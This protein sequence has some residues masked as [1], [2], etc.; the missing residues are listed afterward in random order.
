MNQKLSHSFG[1]FFPISP[2]PIFAVCI[3]AHSRFAKTEEVALRRIQSE[4]LPILG[5]HSPLASFATA[6]LP[7]ALNGDKL[8]VDNLLD[9]LCSQGVY[10]QFSVQLHAALSTKGRSPKWFQAWFNSI[11]SSRE[12]TNNIKLEVGSKILKTCEHEIAFHLSFP[13]DW[14]QVLISVLGACKPF[15]V[16]C[17]FKT[18]IGG[19]TTSSLMHEPIIRNCLLGCSDCQDNINHY[20]QCSPLWQIARVALGVTDLF[21]SSERLCIVSPTVGNAQL[22]ALVYHLAHNMFKGGDVV[23]P[24]P[25]AVQ[26]NLVQAAKAFRHQIFR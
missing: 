26:L 2:K 24:M 11:H 14:Y 19:W 25:R 22:L 3:A 13:G 8:L 12:C 15:V 21:N 17:L 6:S 23:S 4:A 16:M 10:L 5:V 18:Y 1:D 9:S 7:S 20:L